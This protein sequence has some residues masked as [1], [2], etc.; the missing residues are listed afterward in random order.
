[1]AMSQRYVVNQ[2]P[3]STVFSWI[4]QGEIAIPEI[5]RPFV[6]NATKVRN[7]L[8]S[9]YQGFPVGF[10]IA[11]K[12][13]DVKLKDGSKATGKR[14]L[15]DGQQ[16]VTAL[17]AALLGEEVV[18]KD[19]KRVR[20]RIGFN[21][22]EERFEVANSAMRKNLSWIP[23]VS[24]LFDA[25]LDLF[26]YVNT[27]CAVNPG[28][29]QGRVFKSI[30]SLQGIASNQIGLIELDSSLDIETVT[31]IFIR[32]NSAGVPLSQADFA[33]S[34]IAVNETN[35][36]NELRKVID[37]FCHLAIAP[38][39]YKDISNDRSFASSGA[40][41]HIAWMKNESDALYDPD[42]VDVLRVT[43]TS[44]FKRG[45]L[46]DL[47]ALLSGRNFETLQFEESIV[48]DTFLRLRQSVNRFTNESNF[49]KFL[50]ILRSTGFID[51]AMLTATNAVNF[52][53]ILYLI[54]R[55]RELPQHLVERYVRRWFVMS[56]L[57]SRHSGSFESTFTQDVRLI[58]EHGIV[59][60]ADQLFRTELSD[61][62]WELGLPGALNT[63]TI[64]SPY[65]KL[66]QASQVKGNDHGFL[67]S[68]I[69][70][71][72]LIQVKSDIHHLFPKNYLEKH[73]VP[74]SQYNQIAN[75]AQ[76]Q[77]EIN[78]AIGNK[79]PSVYFGQ[80]LDQVG[81]GP[82]RYGN[83]SGPDELAANLRAN[84]IPLDMATMD[85]MN[86]PTFLEERRK[87]IAAKIRTYFE[88]L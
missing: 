29:Q 83:I 57:T 65:Y 46:A 47:V 38:D 13:P 28:L 43:F 21:P 14:I 22:A 3:V 44:E 56:M 19:Y 53:Y 12:N 59:S 84:A 11:W 16:R 25:S 26:D 64:A 74:K 63:A 30:Q 87:L 61:T 18:D 81:G 78:I 4:E 40:L 67:S 37:Y 33:M 31:E 17:R 41:N 23:D 55:R 42:Y 27:Y 39:A 49:K 69:T 48:E 5:Q 77:S 68:D 60:Y 86:Y 6:W 88:G 34:K 35:G 75:F 70:V 72:D 73:G 24:V 80:L 71:K 2:P 15:I 82:H 1:M 20:I 32:V 52:A 50:L 54:L 85:A 36:G 8:D 45:R 9:L 58:D 7:L 51:P 10:L 62:F 66:F 79:A 76:T